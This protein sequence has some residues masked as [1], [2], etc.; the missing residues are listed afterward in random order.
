MTTSTSNWSELLKKAVTEP[1]LISKAYN[2]F[3]GYSL[4]NRMHAMCECME[5]NI[6]PGPIATFKAWQEKGRYVLK[7]QKAISL[8]MPVTMKGEKERDGVKE[9]FTFNRFIFRNNW[10]VLSQTEGKE[11]EIPVIPEWKKEIA[12]EKLSIKEIPFDNCNG[13]IMGFA[14]ASSEIAINPLNPMPWKTLFHELAHIVLGHTSEGQLAD[15]EETPRDIRE[16]EAESVSLLVC[17]SLGLPG[18]EY[19][20][21]Y[22]QNW[23]KGNEVPEKSAQR[24]FSAAN[25]ILES[26]KETL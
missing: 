3:Y 16:L 11:V 22:I 17:E 4:G 24:I 18:Q 10:F 9:E 8:C 12:L 2:A 19:S 7:G 26:G 6:T 14:T 5:R 25:K 15:S 20:R 23:Y 13:N 1:G 21:G